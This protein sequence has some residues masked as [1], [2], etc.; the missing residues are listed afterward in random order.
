MRKVAPRAGLEPATLRLTAGCSTVELP[1]NNA[2]APH[3]AR[4]AAK[5]GTISLSYAPARDAQTNHLLLALAATL[6]AGPEP[7]ARQTSAPAAR[8]TTGSPAR[9]PP[10]PPARQ[11][12][13]PPARPQPAVRLGLGPVGRP[14]PQFH[15]LREGAR[16]RP[17]P[18]ADRRSSGPARSARATPPSSSR[19]AAST[20][21][22]GPS[23]CV[24][25]VRRSQEEVIRRS[26]PRPAR[27]C[28][29]S[30][31][32]RRPTTSTSL[33]RGAAL[34]AAPRRRPLYAT[35][36]RRNCSR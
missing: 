18:P 11:A 16:L 27:P 19:A 23:G 35:S 34:D 36:T 15:V 5:A 29:N 21:C 20:R 7:A 9:R 8:Q 3:Y 26:M 1:R 2:G 6:V 13:A 22:T 24:A 25:M 10:A 28:G 12:L 30:R 32:R 4:R 33:G 31:T 17:G 14:E